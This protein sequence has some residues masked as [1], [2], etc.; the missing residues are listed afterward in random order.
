ME[1]KEALTGARGAMGDTFDAYV[2]GRARDLY[3]AHFG[4]PEDRR[5]AV[6]RA[7]RP[8]AAEVADALEA[9]Q[10]RLAPSAARAEH[11]AALR[12]GAAAVVTGQ[13]VSLFLGPL[14]TLYKAASAVR[15]ARALS[16]ETGQNVVPM[17]WLQTEDHDLPEIAR[18]HVRTA[19]APLTLHVPIPA[20]N[21]VS[22]AHC[23]L[24]HAVSECLARL[25]TEL[26]NLP[27]AAEHLSRL[28]RHYRPG[29][30]CAQAFAGVLA[31][32]FAADGLLVLD[33]RDPALAAS[34]AVLHRRALEDAEP[35]SNAL[36]EQGRVLEARGWHVPVHVRE[37]VPLSFFHA[38]SPEGPR[39]RLAPALDDGYAEIGGKRTYAL[40][41]LLDYL[42]REPVRFSTSAL[43]RPILQDTLLPTAAYVGGPAE[44]AY[45][46][47][48]PPLYAAY[49]L[50][51]PLIVPRARFR[52]LEHRVGQLLTRLGLAA[53]DL[54]RPTSELL[55]KLP[56]A[57]GIQQ[58]PATLECTLVDGFESA[59]RGAFAKVTAEGPALAT[60]V[61][62]MRSIVRQTAAKLRKKYEKALLHQDRSWMEDTERL[63]TLL[64]PEGVPQERFY[65]ISYFAARYGERAFVERVLESVTPFD[66]TPKDLRL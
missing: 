66:A 3:G 47:Q 63:K 10:A 6:L 26:G 24:P 54:T 64:Y 22:V 7:I 46:A 16:D 37:S 58:S 45:F 11:F 2:S 8:L 38:E 34:A 59:L 42:E 57:K 43:L 49:G 14:Y 17:F 61:E 35:I 19:G 9:Q 28:A 40:H 15:V 18:C 12:R 21:H 36:L 23:R 20:N 53:D 27:H 51:M 41:E 48:L 60:A 25:H 29:A 44:V 62:N 4:S 33:P 5:R 13:Q 30:G 56:F 32:L 55:A 52:V 31:E 50:S 1:E 65:G 39:Y